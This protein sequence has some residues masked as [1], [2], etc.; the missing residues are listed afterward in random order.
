MSDRVL[1]LPANQTES[2][3]VQART[4]VTMRGEQAVQSNGG[5]G[6]WMPEKRDE[7]PKFTLKN[8]DQVDADWTVI[9]YESLVAMQDVRPRRF[10]SLL[11]LAQGR[12]GDVVADDL[13]YFKEAGFITPAGAL[14]SDVQSVLVSAYQETPE[15]AVL[16]NPVRLE[17]QADRAAV[18]RIEQTLNQR[19][20]DFLN[21][22][23]AEGPSLN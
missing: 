22:R 20:R 12:A 3:V 11:A 9:L 1:R 15:G 5:P 6:A 21:E 10:Q 19:A 23:D 8:G 13:E 7:G 16:I 14:S 4:G 18:E 2:S 17:T